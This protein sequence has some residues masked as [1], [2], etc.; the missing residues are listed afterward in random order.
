MSFVNRTLRHPHLLVAALGAFAIFCWWHIRLLDDLREHIPDLL[1]W[2]ALSFAAYLASLGLV[3]RF[4][5]AGAGTGPRVGWMVGAIV[6]WGLCA[7]LL[8]LHTD[9][10]LS[11][12]LHRYLWDGRVQL[13]GVNPYQYAPSDRALAP[14][15]DSAFDAIL[16]PHLR[17]VYPPV[18]Q[19]AF[20][21]GAWLH[22]SLLGQKLVVLLAELGI[23]ASLLFILWARRLSLLWVLAYA[24]HPLVIL[25][26]AGSGHHDAVG[27]AFLWVGLA[28]WHAR[29]W[30]PTTVAWTAAF[31]SKF[32]SIVLAPWWV[33]RREARRWLA[34][35]FL[36][37]AAPLLLWP[38]ALSALVESLTAVTGRVESN[39][40]FYLVWL[41]VVGEPGVA[42]WVSIAIGAGVLLWWGRRESDPVRF[43]L[44]AFSAMALL[45]P[46]LHPWYVLWLVPFLC[47]WRVPAVI[48]LTGTVLLAYTVW[49]T[50]LAE[51]TWRVPLWAR[52]L[53]YVPVGVLGMW[54]LCRWQ[55]TSSFRL[56]TKPQVSLKS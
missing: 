20:R 53:E 2:C 26:L 40:S 29:Q 21:L 50:Y 24:W 25:E 38:N 15:R 7:R 28:A 6:L 33:F 45:T 52:L 18:A 11:P 39:A 5:S 32:L 42:R 3:R 49:P 36:L 12:D 37:A 41:G 27:M 35:F 16:L 10:T 9:P 47:F 44:G 17:T 34:A 31:L 23:M 19:A 43:L 14:L 30:L 22:P 56:A 51:G 1:G 46:V 54:E 4:A 13:A 8:L 55:W 48:A